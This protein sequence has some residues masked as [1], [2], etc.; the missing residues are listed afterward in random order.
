VSCACPPHNA[1]TRTFARYE[2]RSQ[3]GGKKVL[4]WRRGYWCRSASSRKPGCRGCALR[5]AVRAAAQKLHQP[6]HCCFG[7]CQRVH[8]GETNI[9][10]EFTAAAP[11]KQ[12]MAVCTSCSA[13][14]QQ[15]AHTWY[16]PSG[17]WPD[18]PGLA[19]SCRCAAKSQEAVILLPTLWMLCPDAACWRLVPCLR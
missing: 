4:R 10:D 15:G 13:L 12:H 11:L 14:I 6:P 7:S 8:Y 19:A 16:P 17:S 9:H 3:K 18:H 5:S 1:T 2:P